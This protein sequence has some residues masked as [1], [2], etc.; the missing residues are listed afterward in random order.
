MVPKEKQEKN[1][2]E[3]RKA[4]EESNNTMS[5]IKLDMKRACLFLS[6]PSSPS[7]VFSFC[8]FCSPFGL[9]HSDP[10]SSCSGILKISYKESQLHRAKEE[11]N[12]ANQEERERDNNGDEERP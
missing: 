2:E 11:R 12:I 10:P 3:I 8:S 4:W 7:P 5:V 9:P 6:P 1:T